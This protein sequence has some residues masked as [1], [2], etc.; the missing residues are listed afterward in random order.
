MSNGE[1]SNFDASNPMFK[2][3][4]KDKIIPFNSVIFRIE[5]MYLKV[6]SCVYGIKFTDYEHNTLLATGYIG[7]PSYRADPDYGI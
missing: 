6:N 4:F 2:V 1:R 3:E 7:T 5:V